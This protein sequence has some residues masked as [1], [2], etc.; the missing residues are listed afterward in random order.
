M[1]EPVKCLLEVNLES[2][3]RF[4]E[5]R[6]PERDATRKIFIQVR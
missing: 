2:V 3:A 4:K 1:A 5:I 6:S